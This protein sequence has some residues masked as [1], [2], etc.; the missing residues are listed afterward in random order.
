[1]RNA[2][3]LSV[4]LA[5][6]LPAVVGGCGR[7]QAGEGPPAAC[8]HLEVSSAE[9]TG[10]Q[11]AELFSATRTIDLTFTVKFHKG[12]TGDHVLELRVLTPDGHLYRSLVTPITADGSREPRAVP[13]AGH[14]RPV[15]ERPL[16]LWGPAGQRT[17]DV[18]FPVAGTDI[19]SAGL[20]GM[21][22]VEA[23]LDRGRT[24]CNLVTT[25][26]LTE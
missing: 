16:R 8:Q 14:R 7:A 12:F 19:L 5:A 24:A 4:L 22:R 17:V 23:R 21:W 2:R 25:F 26:T 1:M 15:T 6:L 3:P 11:A 10:G 9:E 20:Y 13:L 18:S